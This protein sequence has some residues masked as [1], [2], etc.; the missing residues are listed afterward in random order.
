MNN[1]RYANYLRKDRR[2][3]QILKLNSHEPTLNQVN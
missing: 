2:C 3:V 1:I